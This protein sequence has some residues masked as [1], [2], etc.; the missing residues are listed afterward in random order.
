MFSTS[1]QD[2]LNRF[3]GAMLEHCT[4]HALGFLLVIAT[5]SCFAD[6]IC[7][8][9]C[10]KKDDCGRSVDCVFCNPINGFCSPNP[11]SYYYLPKQKNDTNTERENYTIAA[12]V[13][14][15]FV[16]VICCVG[17]AI[18]ISWQRRRYAVARRS[19][20]VVRTYATNRGPS[21]TSFATAVATP[22]YGAT[23]PIAVPVALDASYGGVEVATAST[24]PAGSSTV[25]VEH[26]VPVVT[27]V[28]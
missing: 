19:S 27:A 12:L 15:S 11:Y 23:G 8:L 1:L 26:A 21:S 3:R 2:S 16:G 4:T 7:G 24:V 13:T 20:L 5:S 18:A 17:I 25:V 6:P 28:Y 22:M 10:V 14:V 9:N